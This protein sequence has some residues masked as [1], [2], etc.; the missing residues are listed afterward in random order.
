MKDVQLTLIR[1]KFW[2]NLLRILFLVNFHI[3][4]PNSGQQQGSLRLNL[5]NLT[6]TY[7]NLMELKRTKIRQTIL[8]HIKNSDL[9]T[10]NRNHGRNY[11]I[12]QN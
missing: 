11:N 2:I 12:G 8:Q 6:Y 10:L 3:L 1:Y 9:D 4:V 5:N 7:Q